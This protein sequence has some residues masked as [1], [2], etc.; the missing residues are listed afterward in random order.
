MNNEDRF[1][2]I[3]DRIKEV[4]ESGETDTKLG[5]T[6]AR[7]KDHEVP[8][9]RDGRWLLEGFIMEAKRQ[10]EILSAIDPAISPDLPSHL[11][12]PVQIAN[13]WGLP[14]EEFNG[15]SGQPITAECKRSDTHEDYGEPPQEV[16]TAEAAEILG[17]SKDTVL[18]LKAAGLLEYRNMAPPDSSRPVFAFT[19]RSVMELRTS[20][21]REEPTP[22]MPSEPQR[23][24][25]A[26]QSK[27]Y[28]H[29]KLED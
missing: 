16:G 22:P 5:Q 2:H 24:R 7:W 18:K 9:Q 4:T 20:Y 3:I 17:V 28:K 6:L 11:L 27:K 8:I 10:R 1:Q 26:P 12:D 15:F 13:F 25:V 21:E 29:V 23:R 19:L 14:L